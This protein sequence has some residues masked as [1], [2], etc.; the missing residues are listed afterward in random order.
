MA[1]CVAVVV[2]SAH[3]AGTG[4]YRR[5]FRKHVSETRS[6][7]RGGGRNIHFNPRLATFPFIIIIIFIAQ[8]NQF[9]QKAP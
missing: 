9:K 1:V 5:Y 3:G 2:A 8:S 7:R 4:K 6:V